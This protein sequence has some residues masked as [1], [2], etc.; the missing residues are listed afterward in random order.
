MTLEALDCPTARLSLSSV[1]NFRDA[2]GH[3]RP[4][5]GHGGAALRPGQFYRSGTLDPDEADSSLLSGLPVSLVVDLRT[6][7]E[8]ERRPD[9]VPPGARYAHISVLGSGTQAEQA[10][11]GHIPDPDEARESL[12]KLNRGFVTDPEQ[13]DQFR[14]VFHAFAEAD[15][16]GP[17]GAVVFHCSYGKDRSGWTAAMLLFIA[18]VSDSDVLADYLLSNAFLAEVNRTRLEQAQAQ[19]GPEAANARAPI[20]EVHPDYLGTGLAQVERDYGTVDEY[21][22]RG[23][24]LDEQ[25][26][27]RLREKLLR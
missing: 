22:R 2:V 23:L 20:F 15:G 25:V 9:R 7:W 21:L 13:R 19:D 3:P 1:V 5:A 17:N 26:L 4:L 8:V 24:G 27:G 18:G 14:A 11:Y 12:R 6:P 10:V 16:A